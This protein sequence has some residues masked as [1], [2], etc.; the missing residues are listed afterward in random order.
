VG[1]QSLIEIAFK[2]WLVL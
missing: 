1:G 2:S